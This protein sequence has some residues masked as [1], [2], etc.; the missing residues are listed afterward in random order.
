MNGK[1]VK[2]LGWCGK[3]FFSEDPAC[4]RFCKKCRTLRDNA[5]LSKWDK[6]TMKS[7]NPEEN[8]TTRNVWYDNL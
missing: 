2:C 7:T 6:H 1:N 4:I 3:E 5:K 8:L